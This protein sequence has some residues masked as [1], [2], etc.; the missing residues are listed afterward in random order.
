VTY[1]ARDKLRAIDGVLYGVLGRTGG[2]TVYYYLERYY[3]LRKTEIPERLE[4]FALGI[5]DVFRSS[6]PIIEKLIVKKLESRLA[7]THKGEKPYEF[8]EFMKK[9]QEPV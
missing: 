9:I 8:L 3:E 7:L 1:R 2:E 4:T 5:E 6:A